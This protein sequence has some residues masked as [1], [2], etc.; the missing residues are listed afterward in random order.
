MPKTDP[1]VDDYIAK[2]RPFAQPVLRHLRKLV[3][4]GCP[5]V[6]ESIRWSHISFSHQG[7][8]LAGMAAFKEHLSFGFWHK[9]MEPILVRDGYKPGDA[10]GLMGRIS[11][12]D[13]IPSDAKMARYVEMAVAL[14][15]S[16]EPARARPKPGPKAPLRIPPTL[17]AALKK[18]R[19]AAATW[20]KLSYS[21]RKEY[22]EWLTEAKREE[23][24]ATRLA[25]TVEWLAEGKSRNWKYENC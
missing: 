15:E 2:S 5:E 14:L 7:R 19:K 12:L 3:H 25:T 20:D 18:N 13:H 23:T 6:E 11:S 4:R 1:R 17:T 22:L 10:M 21:H 16:G 24:K 8:I 9:D